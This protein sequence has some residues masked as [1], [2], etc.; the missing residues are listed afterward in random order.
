MEAFFFW[1]YQERR[2][3]GEKKLGSQWHIITA[4]I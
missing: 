3:Y 2:K 1:Q 4:A